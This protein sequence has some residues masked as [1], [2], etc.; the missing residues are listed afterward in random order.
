MPRRRKRSDWIESKQQLANCL[1]YAPHDG[2]VVYARD[3]RGSVEIFEGAIVRER[4]EILNLPDLSRMEVKT[5]VHEAV[6]DQVQARVAD[7]GS[8]GCVSRSSLSSRCRQG[9][10]RAFVGLAASLVAEA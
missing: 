7:D 6:L 5:Q 8:S 10:R 2:M 4:Q 1:I 9:G 3:R